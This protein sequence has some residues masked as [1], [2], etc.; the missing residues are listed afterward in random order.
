MKVELKTIWPSE[1]KEILQ[2]KNYNNRPISAISVKKIA[3]D[4]NNGSYVLTHQAIA[5]D[6]TGRLIDGQHRL[7]ACVM[8]NKPIAILV[9]TGLP[10]S[11]N[12]GDGVINTFEVIDS[13]KSRNVSQMLLLSGMKNSSQ[14]A[15]TAKAVGLI[16]CRSNHNFGVSIA[17]THKILHLIGD[18][19]NTCVEIGKS[20]AILKAPAYITGPVSIY[21]N[22]FPDK[23]IRFLQEFVNVSQPEGSNSPSRTLAKY[24]SNNTS[25]CGGQQ[26]I[27]R[28]N[29]VC[30]AIYKFHLGQNMIKASSSEDSRD[31]LVKLNIE[32]CNRIKNV[33][34]SD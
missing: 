32:I 3:N 23:A 27:G 12:V 22:S 25:T 31:W 15:A 13:G 28:Y 9:A 18:S 30:N 21:H 19:I 14:V 11:Q 24:H 29:I 26:Q 8:A 20:G 6:V 7:S 33:I 34:I 2:T 5:F 17:Q 10:V 4:I 1:A 16:C